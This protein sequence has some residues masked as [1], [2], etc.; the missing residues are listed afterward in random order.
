MISSVDLACYGVIHAKGRVSVDCGTKID[1]CL[2]IRVLFEHC[3]SL[4]YAFTETPKGT[5]PFR[6]L[7]E[8]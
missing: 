7:S 3:F 5:F 4:A 2:G 8:N 6:Y 1:V